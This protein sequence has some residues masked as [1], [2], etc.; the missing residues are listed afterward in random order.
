M[1][2]ATGGGGGGGVQG[3][4][5]AAV[6]ALA[7]GVITAPDAHKR[8]SGARAT[9][10]RD[11][12]VLTGRVAVRF[13]LGGGGA[14]SASDDG[15]AACRE[16]VRAEAAA[17]P[18]DTLLVDAR[19]CHIWHSPAKVH[20]WFKAALRLFPSTAWLGKTEDDALPWPSA[21]V[22]DLETLSPRVQ[23]YGLMAWQGSCRGGWAAHGDGDGDGGA[24][25]AAAA[26]E[27][28]AAAQEA[29]DLLAT[30]RHS[31]PLECMGCF[32]GL[33][34]GGPSVCRATTCRNA[35]SGRRCCQLGCPNAV[36]MAPFAVGPLEV[37][38]RA[39]AASV[40]AC[41]YAD[42][43]F[44]R[45]TA[46]GA[47]RGALC[48]TTD[49]SQ[50]HAIAECLPKRGRG[51]GAAASL[52]VADAGHGRLLDGG[53]SCRMGVGRCALQQAVMLHPLK[54][55]DLIA[56]N[57]SWRTLT[58]GGGGQLGGAQARGGGQ[59]GATDHVFY[60]PQPIHEATVSHLAP[61]AL[62]M[63]RPPAQQLLS[64]AGA[65]DLARAWT[66]RAQYLNG[67]FQ[68]RRPNPSPTSGARAAAAS[69]AEAPQRPRQPKRRRLRSVGIE[70]RNCTFVWS[71]ERESPYMDMS[72]FTS[73]RAAAFAR[74]A[75][76]VQ[77]RRAAASM[78]S[79]S[80]MSTAT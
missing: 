36:R 26:E 31:A 22:A 51:G 37:R 41:A 47:A 45:L 17:H 23:Y 53:G 61:A 75:A 58:G 1:A 54:R 73:S 49:G 8:R 50:G 52:V 48:S 68:R 24:T 19:D 55:S 44:A 60:H 40:A 38:T 71:G 56:W 20:A 7:L 69:E 80:S 35:P 18:A 11:P 34:S 15:D 59:L 74:A 29:A 65:P 3:A 63:A 64:P 21:V 66:S 72:M 76:A 33:F 32:G 43:Y 70:A 25:T 30:N 13:V 79:S 2:L 10:L 4:H 78:S 62:P 28:A 42:A 14:R 9:W 16:S 39:L 67:I 27:A 6:P 46:T 12:A 5:V 57:S 77:S